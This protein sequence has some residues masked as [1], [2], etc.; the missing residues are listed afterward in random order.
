[1][2]KLFI[3]NFGVDLLI[4]NE[5]QMPLHRNES[6]FQKT[7]NF[8]GLD[9][10]VKENYLLAQERVTVYAQVAND[11]SVKLLPE[12]VFK[13]KGT[14]TKV[15]APKNMHYQW[16][17]KGSYCLEQMLK[18]ISHPPNCFNMFTPKNCAIYVLDDYNVHLLPE[19]KEALLKCGY[20]YVGMGRGIT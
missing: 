8:T 18:T 16:A 11:S 7:L 6:A 17:P 3:D 15:N 2:Q 1:M 10:Y 19:V 20:V 12:F 14:H 13:G 9:T 4:V 5:D